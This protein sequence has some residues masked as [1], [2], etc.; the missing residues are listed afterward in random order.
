MA[1]VRALDENGDFTFGQNKSNYIKDEYALKQNVSTRLLEWKN[2]CFF[3]KEAGVDYDYFLGTKQVKIEFENAIRSVILQTED[4]RAI[5][6]FSVQVDG[7]DTEV[8]AIISS[9]YGIFNLN[10]GI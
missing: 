8:F 10:I 1:V 9:I 7:R 5:D 2:D 3:D 4:V 6:K